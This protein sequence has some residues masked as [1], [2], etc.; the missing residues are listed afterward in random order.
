MDR[1]TWTL[2]LA[3]AVSY[4]GDIFQYESSKNRGM[5]IRR[6]IDTF[7]SVVGDD[8]RSG[9]GGQLSIFWSN[10]ELILSL[11]MGAAGQVG[12]QCPASTE[13]RLFITDG[14][15]VVDMVLFDLCSMLE[16]L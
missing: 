1:I 8:G 15:F 7:T 3:P 12:I 10:E 14:V 9:T 6:L 16:N 11:L 2:S 13:T 4:S 5:G